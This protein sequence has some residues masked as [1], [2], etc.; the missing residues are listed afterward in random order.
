VRVF[1]ST[2]FYYEELVESLPDEADGG[3]GGERDRVF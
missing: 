2:D 1:A 3:G